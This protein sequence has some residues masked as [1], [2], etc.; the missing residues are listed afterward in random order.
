MDE[1]EF[2][3]VVVRWTSDWLASHGTTNIG[4]VRAEAPSWIGGSRKRRDITLKGRYLPR[5]LITVELKVPENR[6]EGNSPANEIL[7]KDAYDKARKANVKYFATWNVK[8]LAVWSIEN[9][10]GDARP[11]HTFKILPGLRHSDDLDVPAIAAEGREQWWSVLDYLEKLVSPFASPGAIPFDIQQLL[12][13]KELVEQ[14]A[15]AILPDLTDRCVNDT[16]F[17]RKLLKYC[18]ETFGWHAAL[19]TDAH[20]RGN[21]QVELGQI[22]RLAAFVQVNKI[23]FYQLLFTKGPRLEPSHR[24]ELPELQVGTH[25]ITG[26]MV[27]ATMVDGYFKEASRIS[28]DYESVFESGFADDI[29]FVDAVTRPSNRA[30]GS[31]WSEVCQKVSHL[32]L[33]K[34]P[35]DII[36]S[37]YEEVIPTELRYELGQY[38]TPIEVV[39]LILAFCIRDASDT[40]L[41]TSTGGGSF[42]IRAYHRK[43]MLGPER[44][45]SKMMSE[46]YGCEIA[47]F[48]AHLAVLGLASQNFDAL[49]SYPQI[50]ARKCLD[51][52]APIRK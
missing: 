6:R 47:Q 14:T 4:D 49:A 19:S 16:T 15:V 51:R 11:L 5:P 46:L 29:A 13:L 37:L 23:I 1:R 32:K 12:K 2:Q 3:S 48:P 40:V 44:A 10:P 21:L 45:H 30:A 41:D 42:L 34:L 22:A 18:D 52:S 9:A 24:F 26:A 27:K 25:L 17:R 36:H 50:I 38:Y 35:V 43:K 31:L 20:E 28:G 33:D 7:V 8:E 39:D